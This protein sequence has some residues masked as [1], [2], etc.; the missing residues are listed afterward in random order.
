MS[1]NGSTAIDCSEHGFWRTEGVGT[2]GVI[3][4][5]VDGAAPAAG[6]YPAN[7]SRR[8]TCST[9]AREFAEMIGMNKAQVLICFLIAESQA[10]PPRSSFWSNHTSIPA[11]RRLVQI[12]AAASVSS[13]A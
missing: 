2:A 4:R 11:L 3:G 6:T 7:A 5:L 13:E 8:D 9:K 12:R 10:A 1:T